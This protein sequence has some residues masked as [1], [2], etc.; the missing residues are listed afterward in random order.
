MM[1]S[2]LLHKSDLRLSPPRAHTSPG[3]TPGTISLT[4]G[5]IA[6][7][8]HQ[9]SL[10][11]K[12][13]KA[14]TYSSP[15]PVACNPD[16]NVCKV[17]TYRGEKVAAFNVEGRELIC[18]PQA[19]ELFLKHLVGG[20]HTVYTK[21]K[22]LDITPV[23]CNVEQ[24]R[25]LRGLGAIQPGVNRCKLISCKEFD[26]LYEDCTN[27]SARPGRP[28]K[29]SPSIHASPETLEKLKKCRVDGDYPFDPRLYDRKAF[30]NG[31]AHHP[32]AMGHLPF[33]PLNPVNMLANPVSM[34]MPSHL[35]FRPDGGIMKD[36]SSSESDILSPR[37]RDD[38]YESI[39]KVGN[40]TP[41]YDNERHKDHMDYDNNKPLNL[42]I[43]GDI[44]DL[45]SKNNGKSD[46]EMDDDD[47]LSDDNDLE[48]SLAG[49]DSINSDIDNKDIPSSSDLHNQVQNGDFPNISSIESLL[50]NIQGMLKLAME[51]ARRQER[52]LT[53]EKTELKM[54]LLREREVREGLEKQLQEEQKNKVMLI[55]RVKREKRVRKRLQEQMGVGS[56]EDPKNN[57]NCDNVSVTSQD[58]D[59]HNE[60]FHEKE[61]DK[62]TVSDSDKKSTNDVKVD[63]PSHLFENL[64]SPNNNNTGSSNNNNTGGGTNRF[65]YLPLTKGDMKAC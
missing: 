33:M 55:K 7:V 64:L 23:V 57:P 56:S 39:H 48:D 28:P 31:F 27:S 38:R 37:M 8:N 12:L 6:T 1:E 47:R 30:L 34:A 15:P 52:Q 41:P 62:D 14:S 22:R 53:Y 2:P 50:L 42:H 26:I 44:R 51:N 11:S 17:I 29:R 45:S 60:S 59:K 63:R 25:I 54:E 61:T 24:V 18:L 21:L 43:N 10:L 58:S 5:M 46:D 9:N 65:P 32:Y 49:S 13:H 20:L 4:H 19:F 40:L 3:P 35:G 16:N 36:R